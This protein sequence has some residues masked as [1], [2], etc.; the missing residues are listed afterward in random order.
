MSAGLWRDKPATPTQQ[1]LVFGS[2]RGTATQADVLAQLMR[3]CRARGAALELPEILRAGIARFTARI[4]ELRKRGFV[5]ENELEHV[6]GQLRTH[7]WLRHDPEQD[8]AL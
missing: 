3:D 7:Y 8:G 5:T 2:G 4:H 1:R 6:N